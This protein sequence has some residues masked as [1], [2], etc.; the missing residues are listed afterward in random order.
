MYDWSTVFSSFRVYFTTFVHNSPHLPLYKY[1]GEVGLYVYIIFIN[2]T[3]VE[4]QEKSC[5]TSI[6][7][8]ESRQA[9][10]CNLTLYSRHFW[11]PSFFRDLLQQSQQGRKKNNSRRKQRSWVIV[12]LRSFRGSCRV[13]RAVSRAAVK[14]IVIVIVKSLLRC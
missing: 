3:N 14:V 7:S 1:Q 2:G 12:N 11:Q 10:V 13:S 6:Y 4:T 8:T 9:I 5:R